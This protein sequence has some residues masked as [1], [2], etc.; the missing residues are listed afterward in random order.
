MSIPARAAA[1][2]TMMS[3]GRALTWV[4][5]MRRLIMHDNSDPLRLAPEIVA[6]AGSLLTQR[7]NALGLDLIRQ[8][9][10]GLL[11]RAWRDIADDETVQAAAEKLTIDDQHFVV[12]VHSF[13]SW[14][15]SSAINRPMR[16]LQ[17]T[18][19]EPFLDWETTKLRISDLARRTGEFSPASR[20]MIEE[21]TAAVEDGNLLRRS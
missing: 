16:P 10:P 1:L 2:H 6:E 19:V 17:K 3:S 20:A 13:R 18:D 15:S 21:I 12:L 4:A 14:A 8:P 7:F 11:L 9:R 5:D